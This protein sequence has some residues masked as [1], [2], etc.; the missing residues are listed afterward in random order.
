M[1]NRER[2]AGSAREFDR[3]DEEAERILSVFFD[4]GDG[5]STLQHD[6]IANALRDAEARAW[7]EAAK[8]G[9]SLSPEKCAAKAAE[10]R[11]SR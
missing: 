11:G 3:H 7:E 2:E 10:I 6:A 4:M 8:M 1:D 5:W 9:L